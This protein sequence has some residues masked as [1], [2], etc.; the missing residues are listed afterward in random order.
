LAYRGV[1]LKE[2]FCRAAEAAIEEIDQPFL[3]K[4]A[5]IKPTKKR[6]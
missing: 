3:I 6:K 1:S 4:E 2:W 5:H